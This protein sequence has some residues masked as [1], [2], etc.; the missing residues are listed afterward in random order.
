V[1]SALD[2][3]GLSRVRVGTVDKFQGQEAAVA[4]VTLAA[5]S[6]DDAP[7][8]MSFLIM[9]N[10]LN[11]AISRAKWAAYLVH[12][13]ALTEYLPITPA[14]VAELSAFITLLESGEEQ[15]PELADAASASTDALAL[16]RG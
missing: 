6:P 4:I 12:S 11:V 7:R 3:A 2:D 14:G 8:G 10:R 16:S 15:V 5:S 9:K 1:R 13:P